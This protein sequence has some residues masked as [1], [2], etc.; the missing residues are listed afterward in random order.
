MQYSEMTKEALASEYE[1]LKAAHAALAAAG[2]KLDLSRGKPAADQLDLSDALLE[3][4]IAKADCLLDGGLD[5]RNY[6]VPLGLPEMRAFWSTL[7]GIPAEQIYVGGNSSLALMYDTIVRGMLFGMADSPRPWAEEKKRKFLCPAPGYDRH[8]A[9]T[10]TLGFELIPV[11]MRMDGPDMDE[12]ERLAA[13]PDVKG[14]WC[15]PK[16]SNPTGITFSDDVVYRFASMKTA[17]PD[18]T[19]MWDNAYLVHDLDEDG[20]RLADVFAY[21]R[22]CGTEERFCYFSSTSKITLPGAGVAMF[23]AGPR[24]FA[25]HTKMMGIST[26]GFDKLNQLRHLKMLPDAEAVR[27]QMGRHAAIIREKFDI[28]E[29]VLSRDLGGLGCATWTHPKGGY[30]VSLDLLDGSAKRTYALAKEAGVTLTQVGATFPYGIDPRDRNLRLAPT[31][32]TKGDLLLAAEVLT[33]SVR[34]AAIEK[35]MGKI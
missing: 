18:F 2:H 17:A 16:Y 9:I 1:S 35:L 8:F 32:P 15:V 23:A 19:V 6:G 11:G 31:Y 26:I 30:F 7:T 13:D 29:N 12:V 25:L 22:E 5:A 14:I 4:P 33:V 34:L 27:R 10:E 28:L 3:E 24:N 20:D 21:A